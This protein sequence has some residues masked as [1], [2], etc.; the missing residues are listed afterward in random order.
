VTGVDAE[1]V[2]I[3]RAKALAG[4]Q[5]AANAKFVMADAL[6]LP[7][8]ES[9]YDVTYSNM[10]L[11]WIDDLVAVVKEMARV[12]RRGGHIIARNN[13]Y[14]T[15]V[16]YP[17]MSTSRE[18]S[19]SPGILPRLQ[20][21]GQAWQSLARQRALLDLPQVKTVRGPCHPAG[22]CS[23]MARQGGFRRSCEGVGS[24]TNATNLPSGL[25][26]GTFMVPCP[27]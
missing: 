26:D 16:C 23:D 7:F 6:A 19:A 4:K 22:P 15:A 20:R 12:T 17:R 18:V 13:D 2:A 11:E 27:P 8:G 25:W 1:K 24:S 3:E 10:P 9:V 5:A 14:A 21:K